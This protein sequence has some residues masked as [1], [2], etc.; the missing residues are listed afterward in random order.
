MTLFPEAPL[1]LRPRL[2]GHTEILGPSSK[3]TRR[4]IKIFASKSF[5]HYCWE[6]RFLGRKSLALHLV[7]VGSWSASS[8][9]S[10]AEPGKE[11]VL[12]GGVGVCVPPWGR[13]RASS[14]GFES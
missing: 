1:S 2:P 11:E 9:I 3:D 13:L 4:V 12:G 8:G 6:V 14:L 5:L 10:A 7:I